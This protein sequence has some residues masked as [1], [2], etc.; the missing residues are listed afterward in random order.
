MSKILVVGNGFIANHLPYQKS[1]YYLKVDEFNINGFLDHYKPTTVINCI[2]YC[3]NP[4]I[5]QCEINKTETYTKN[6]AIPLILAA[7]CEKKSI[8]MIHIGSG[9]IA[10]GQSPNIVVEKQSH[11]ERIINRD[12]PRKTLDLGWKENDFFRPKSFYSKTKYATDLVLGEMKNVC[13]LRIR[14]PISYISSPRNLLN[15]ILSYISVVETKNS[16][17]FLD[18][19]V[20]V[21]DWCIQHQ[22]TGIYNV[23][24]P[25]PLY[26]S[27]LIKEYQKYVPEH[28]CE[29]ISELEL[30]YIVNAPRS[31]CILNV[32]KIINEGF[33]F[34]DTRTQVKE[35]IKKYVE[36][37][38]LKNK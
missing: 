1:L 37:N 30:K 29:Y 34:R 35:T 32:D 24:S 18:D 14:M 5:D 21:V 33:V 25:E 16:M 13:T 8:Q 20:N 6:T 31:N 11:F 9:C 38:N 15:K 36:L 17:T 2:G 12:R 28:N 23:V 4:N 22:K 10:Y 7:E 27:N 19:L 3:G 26:H